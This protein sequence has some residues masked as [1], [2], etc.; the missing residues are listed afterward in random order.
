MEFDQITSDETGNQGERVRNSAM[1]HDENPTFSPLLEAIMLPF[2]EHEFEIP[3]CC[4]PPK[5]YCCC[6]IF[7]QF[8]ES[9]NDRFQ[10]IH[11]ERKIS[12]GAEVVSHFVR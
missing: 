5:K 8:I 1:E 7:L 3:S 11:R 6:L 9:H 4:I 2:L 10:K 12:L